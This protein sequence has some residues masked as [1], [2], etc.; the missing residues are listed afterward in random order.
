MNKLMTAA[1][2]NLDIHKS[3]T[4]DLFAASG[5]MMVDHHERLDFDAL[6]CGAHVSQVQG[7]FIENP[8]SAEDQRMITTVSEF[9]QNTPTDHK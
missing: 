7:S 2:A 9:N 3:T 6:E 5:T 4:A 8:M 1:S